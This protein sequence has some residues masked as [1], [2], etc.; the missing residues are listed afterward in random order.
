M[1]VGVLPSCYDVPEMPTLLISKTD[2]EPI[3]LMKDGGPDLDQLA[4]VIY[5]PNCRDNMRG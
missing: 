3:L 2:A 1:Y 5:G 4:G